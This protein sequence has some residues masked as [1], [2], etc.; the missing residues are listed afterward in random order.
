VEEKDA[1]IRAAESAKSQR[2]E[3]AQSKLSKYKDTANR[4][5]SQG[6]QLQKGMA[7]RN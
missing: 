7:A 1:A 3:A 6:Q 4:L 5:K 2:L